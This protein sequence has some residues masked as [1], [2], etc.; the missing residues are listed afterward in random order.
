MCGQAA[1]D[2]MKEPRRCTRWIRSQ[3]A[4]LVRATERSRSM[5]ALLR[6]CMCHVR[7]RALAGGA[8]CNVHAA[9]CGDGGLHNLVAVLHR[10]VVGHR[11]ASRSR[12]LLHDLVRGRT[13]LAAV[14][15]DVS[16]QVVHCA[17][18]R[19]D[20]I[21][22]CSAPPTTDA[23]REAKARAYARPRPVRKSPRCIM[24]NEIK[25]K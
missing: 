19:A 25:M 8:T 5:P 10:V 3:S 15:A 18:F 4:S 22:Q 11:L 6:T 24:A 2:T 21:K 12:D 13:G 16:A 1:R 9:E 17:L 23:P 20:A 7:P 14:A